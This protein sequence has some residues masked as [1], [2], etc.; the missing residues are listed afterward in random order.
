VLDVFGQADVFLAVAL[1]D[2]PTHRVPALV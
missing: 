2:K 1:L